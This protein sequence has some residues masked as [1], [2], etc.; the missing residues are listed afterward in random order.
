[1]PIAL[2]SASSTHTGAIRGQIA[3]TETLLAQAARIGATLVAQGEAVAEHRAW[4]AE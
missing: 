3:L 1:L 2:L 4:L